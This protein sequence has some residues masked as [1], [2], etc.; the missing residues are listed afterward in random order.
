[1]WRVTENDVATVHT[2]TFT[3][4][5][6]RVTEGEEIQ[7][8]VTVQPAVAVETVVSPSAS[9]RSLAGDYTLTPSAITLA[10]GDTGGTAVLRATDEEE[11]EDTEIRSWPF[12]VIQTMRASTTR[13]FPGWT[14][15]GVRGPSR[16]R[17]QSRVPA[18]T[19]ATSPL[20][21]TADPLQ[22]IGAD[23]PSALWA[24]GSRGVADSRG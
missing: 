15:R 11:V 8:A 13:R 20:V 22:H 21:I 1:M 16:R 19:I 3:A 5:A 10:A 14:S 6:D 17:A 24:T 12:G 4:T 7:L 9:P 18:M 2:Y 23:A